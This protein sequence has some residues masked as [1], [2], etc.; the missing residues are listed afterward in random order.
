MYVYNEVRVF[1]GDDL[2][3]PTTVTVADGLITAVG[4][5][6]PPGAD[7]V[8]GR[9]RTLLP[10][11]IDAHAHVVDGDLEQAAAFGVTTVLDMMAD[12]VR[13]AA[14]RETTT[15]PQVADLRT[16]GTAATV[17][18]GYGWYLVE[19]GLLP[20]FP[21]FSDPD[22]AGTFLDE[23]LAEGSDYLKILLDDGSTVGMPTRNMGDAQLH[24]L[25]AAAR[26]RKVRTVAH[27]LTAATARQAAAAG[28]DV[29]GHLFV[30][31]PD[32]ELPAELAARGI[33]VI[34]TLSVL[35]E[36]F[37]RRR[38]GAMAADP[39]VSPYL[40]ERPRAM[41]T[42][43]AVPLG[44]DARHDVEVAWR[45]LGEL[46]AAGVEIL[47]GSDAANPGTAHGVSLHVELRQLVE[48]GLT[49]AEALT[50][51]TA[52]PA[53]RFGLTDRGRIAPGLR[54]DL[55]LVDGD[56][57]ADIDHTLDIAGVWR[58]GR[59]VERLPRTC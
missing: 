29:L 55:L 50:A 58:G 5:P 1:T 31:E 51:A 10:G 20:P 7:V 24:A 15:S 45:T 48:A 11:L 54:A 39:R 37:G 56:P 22:T 53:R 35:G 38:A 27:A 40:R 30:D 47:A 12:P 52:A 18:G 9:G 33:T 57:T 36:L 8:E 49:P 59:R 28:V 32:P 41:L 42:M 4:E 34:P 19:M 21:L 44:E 26:D 14:V 6:P 43:D 25:V 17:P 13:I 23:R 16:A 2:L 46:R 3:S